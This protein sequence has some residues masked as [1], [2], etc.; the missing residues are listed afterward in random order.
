M[1]VEMK[2]NML[3][4][5]ILALLL[6]N[7]VLTSVLMVGVMGTNKKTADLVDN[8]ATDLNLQL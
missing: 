7:I 6:V 3:T 8:I 4:V 5:L 1:G 2:K